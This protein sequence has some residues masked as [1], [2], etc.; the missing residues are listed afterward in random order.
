MMPDGLRLIW[1]SVLLGGVCLALGPGLR[2]QDADDGARAEARAAAEALGG[3]QRIQDVRTIHLY[4]YGQYAYQFGGGNITG[5]RDAPQK[6]QAANDLQRVYDLENGRFLQRERRNF[7][8]PFLAPFG[9]SFALNQLVLDGDIAFNLNANGDAQRVGDS[10][11][12]GILQVDGPHMRRMWMLNNPVVA[13]RAALDPDTTVVG[14]RVEEGVPVLDMTLAEGDTLS[15]AL[16]PQTAL[17]A[18]VRWSN[19]HDNLAEVT[20][21]THLSGYVPYDGVMLPMG[22]TTR[23]DWRDQVYFT[24]YV[25]GYAVDGDIPDLAAPADVRAAPEPEPQPPMIEATPV[26]DGVWRLTGG[27]MVFEF[28]DHLT[29][30][31]LGGGRIR[32]RAVLDFVRTLVPGKIPTELILSHH[33]FDHTAGIREAIADGLTI[34]A[35]RG[36]EGILREVAARPAPNYPDTL[37][38]APQPLR[39]RPVDERLRLEDDTMTVDLYHVVANNHMAHGLFAHV[40]ESRVMVEGDLATAAEEWQFWAD[41]Y[42]DNIEHY[43]IEVDVLAPVHMELMT[44]EEVLD[45]L[46]PGR[47][48]ALERCATFAA[49]GNFLP[50]CPVF[51]PRGG[52]GAVP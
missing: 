41:S 25:D 43:G 14:P 48:R 22:Y 4:G 16:D 28:D 1:M 5:D 20:F 33:H 19:P 34:I 46:A 31:E 23:I 24:M 51:L 26:A 49:G 35:H 11:G 15:V 10:R 50:G 40:P 2:A 12:G 37:S 47:A 52:A 8:F 30:Y 3:L 42:L 7:L 6:W 21:T 45:F 39:F 44:H 13:V 9:H 29:L 17:P 27:T 32:G 36:N 38:R 18:W